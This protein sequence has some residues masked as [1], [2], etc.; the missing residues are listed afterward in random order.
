LLG[1]LRIYS[2]PEQA[3]KQSFLLRSDAEVL[4]NG[5][6]KLGFHLQ[7]KFFAMPPELIVEIR[8]FKKQLWNTLNHDF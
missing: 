6:L 7:R 8:T 3:S 5:N 1:A 2:S 4:A